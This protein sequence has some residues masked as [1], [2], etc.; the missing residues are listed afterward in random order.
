[1]ARL[2]GLG[3]VAPATTQKTGTDWGAVIA[4]V[5]PGVVAARAQDKVMRMNIDREARGLKPLDI[6]NY[7][8]GVKVG[9]DPGTRKML[10]GL[11][12]VTVLVIGGAIYSG[13]NK[14]KAR[15]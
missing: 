14:K 4:Q 2:A 9:I 12:L 10:L 6:E 3:E 8:P 11:G 7:Q 13:R 5:L 15:A 1:M